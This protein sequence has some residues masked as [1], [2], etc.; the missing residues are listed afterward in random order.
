MANEILYAGIG[1]LRVERTLSGFVLELLADRKALPQHPALQYVGD[2]FGRASNVI[3]VP[4]RGLRGYN[5][6][7]TRSDGSAGANTALT[8]GSTDVTVA[9]YFKSY[10]ASDLAFLTDPGNILSMEAFAED[11]VFATAN[12]LTSLVAD[13]T[14]GFTATVGTSGADMSAAVFYEAIATLEAANVEPPYLCI[15]H[16][17]QWNDFLQDFRLNVGGTIPFDPEFRDIGKLRG[18]GYK[19]RLDG[20]DIFVSNRVPTANAGADRAGAMFGP[21]AVVWGDMTKRARNPYDQ[22]VIGGKILFE[23]DRNAKSGTDSA[24]THADLGV[25]KAIDAA[26]VSI[27]TDA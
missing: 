10:E 23:I 5:I 12:T 21:G 8:D 22:M 13:V 7:A 26:G 6:L 24:V 27:I 25:S 2:A 4:H 17:R 19:G 1:D 18:G 9:P 15:L 11:A 3:R 16:S 14:D 20:V